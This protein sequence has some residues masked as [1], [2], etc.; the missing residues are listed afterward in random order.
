MKL[1]VALSA[2]AA[3]SVAG[4]VIS[5]LLQTLKLEKNCVVLLAWKS[6]RAALVLMKRSASPLPRNVDSMHLVLLKLNRIV[7]QA[8]MR[9]SHRTNFLLK[10]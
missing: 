9:K 7:A 3:V 2:F 1:L 5:P 10:A 8:V 4:L 6:A